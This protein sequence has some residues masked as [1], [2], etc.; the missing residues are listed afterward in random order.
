VLDGRD[1]GTVICPDA[2]VKLFVTAS[3][4]VRADRRWR[5]LVGQGAGISRDTVL[6]DIRQRDLRDSTRLDAPMRVAEDAT[7]LDTRPTCRSTRRCGGRSP[8]S[9]ARMPVAASPD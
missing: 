2:A 6:E 8:A 9:R 7:V 5:E 1:I 3:D 4:E